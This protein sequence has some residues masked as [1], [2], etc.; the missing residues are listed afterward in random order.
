MSKIFKETL[1]HLAKDVLIDRE[2]YEMHIY[3]ERDKLVYECADC[4]YIHKR[5][6]A[7]TPLPKMCTACLGLTDEL[8]TTEAEDKVWYFLNDFVTIRAEV[9][10]DYSLE[11]DLLHLSCDCP[12]VIEDLETGILKYTGCT[13]TVDDFEVTVPLCPICEGCIFCRY[14]IEKKDG[15]YTD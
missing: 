12:T 14:A 7:T 11:L 3:K 2:Y 10:S 8:G 9:F 4:G 6:S 5:E 13:Y 15:F 1:W